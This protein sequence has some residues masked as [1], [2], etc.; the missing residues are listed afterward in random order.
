MDHVIIAPHTDDEIIGCY[1]IL[2][3]PDIK[4]IIIYT[5]DIEEERKKECMK[6]KDE[7]EIKAQYFLF[8]IPS[9]LLNPLSNNI[10]Y[11]P[12]PIYETHPEHRYHGMIGESMARNGFDVVFYIT[13][14]NA[15]FKSECPRPNAKLELLN[16]IYPS[17][18]ELW[19]YEHKYFLFSGYD[20]WKFF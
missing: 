1:E 4:P 3:N 20:Q 14:M 10:F 17:Q 9:N 13:E 7:I 19:K 16:K 15:P 8:N 5:T 11:F 2:T 6:L 18:K 12:H